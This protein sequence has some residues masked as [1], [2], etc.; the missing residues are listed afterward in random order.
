[1]GDILLLNGPPGVGKTSTAKIL[2]AALPG[3]VCIYGDDLRAF[4]PQNAR[5]HLGGGSTY[6]VA[7]TLTREYLR[8]GATR[9]VFE[10]CFLAPRHVAYFTDRVDEHV[11]D[12]SLFT[13]W[14]PLGV[15]QQRER[16]RI[17]REALAE[18]VEECWSEI[19][20]NRAAL[21]EFVDNADLDP[22][23]TARRVLTL[24]GE[25]KGRLR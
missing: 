18:K 6:R 23:Q 5:E 10:Y 22:E 21:G 16:G 19:A 2:A 17:L 13:L 20:A 4:A 12:V 25:R 14:A 11:D 8:M 9:V 1:M 3:T 15:I 24:L 7:A